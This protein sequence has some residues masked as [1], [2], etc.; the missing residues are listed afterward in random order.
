VAPP[1]NDETKTVHSF[2]ESSISGINT[3]SKKHH[4]LRSTRGY[5]QN[6]EST[7]PQPSP[8]SLMSLITT[9]PFDTATNDGENKPKLHHRTDQQTQR[10]EIKGKLI[11]TNNLS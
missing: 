6:P 8:C 5:H 10:E 2:H 9:K 3:I 4:E 11:N 1:K 7:N